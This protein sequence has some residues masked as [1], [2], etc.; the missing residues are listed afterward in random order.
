[1]NGIDGVYGRI[2]EL[3]FKLIVVEQCM[4]VLVEIVDYGSIP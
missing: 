1:M 3:Y 2:V 4:E